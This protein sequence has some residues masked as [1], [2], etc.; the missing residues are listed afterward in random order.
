MAPDSVFDQL[1]G[2]NGVDRSKAVI[3]FILLTATALAF[4]TA[5][6]SQSGSD[7]RSWLNWCASIGGTSN[8]DASNP[9]CTPGTGSG[10]GNYYSPPVSVPSWAEIARIQ[11]VEI[12]RQGVEAQERGDLREAIRLYELA[13]RRSPDATIKRNLGVA[14]NNL[15]AEYSHQGNWEE[16][17]RWYQEAQ[18]YYSGP[19]LID[20]IAKVQAA[21]E[22]QA[23][24]AE[25]Q[26]AAE[27]AAQEEQ[28]E[29][30]R[31]QEIIRKNAQHNAELAVVQQRTSELL[32]N[33][34]KNLAKQTSDGNS[35]TP[36][37]GLDFMDGTEAASAAEGNAPC[38]PSQDASVVDLCFTETVTGP[39][40]SHFSS[41][42]ELGPED[43]K[44]IGSMI[45][46]FQK[47]GWSQKELDRLNVALRNLPLEHNLDPAQTRQVWN[48]METRGPASGPAQDAAGGEG[49]VLYRPGQ[50]QQSQDDCAI[51]ALA[52][53]A[54]LPYGVVA[55][56]AGELLRQ[57]EEWRSSTETNNPQQVYDGKP[58]KPGGLNVAEIAILA[59]AFGQA[60][61]IPPSDFSRILKEGR[62]V[63]IGVGLEGGGGHEAVLSKT[64]VHKGE[65][66]Y[67]MM[68]SN[69]KDPLRRLY[70]SAAELDGI[71]LDN[72]LAFRPEPGK[73]PKLLK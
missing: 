41:D 33:L 10:G 2:R 56:R 68:D 15:G 27:I 42:V 5:A 47:E 24:Q 13:F 63:I 11:A 66:W 36:G 49:P 19:V 22:N 37:A 3:G 72:G 9:V 14:Y 12:N 45:A 44:V 26:R 51:Y 8:G 71:L 57:A 70:L 65:T 32:A 29:A 48:D 67:E 35:A 40:S 7:Y 20:N 25:Q 30:E 21:I 62:P 58:G 54:D 28:R 46:M 61:I 23:R 6:N 38:Q 43:E 55:A 53:A 1:S 31:V 64:F 18:R 16:A 17:L 34:S 52:S 73:T 4:A 59:E 60:E 69:Q 50:R 39:V